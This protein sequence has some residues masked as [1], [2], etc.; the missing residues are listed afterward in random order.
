MHLCECPACAK[1]VADDMSAHRA[2]AAV[3]SRIAYCLLIHKSPEQVNDFIRQLLSD[4]SADVYVHI[5]AKA[6]DALHGQI[7]TSPRVRILDTSMAC[8]WGDISLVDATLLLIRAV[9]Q[10]GK[11]YD[12]VCLRSGQDLVVRNGY[13]EYLKAAKTRNFI[14]I[15]KL[16][17]TRSE[18]AFF[19][20]R[21]P[22]RTRQLYDG[23]HPYRL[24]RGLLTRLYLLGIN[25][26]PNR[27]S[28]PKRL[29]LYDGSQWFALSA[30]LV[31]CIIA[32]LDN[33]PSYY[34]AFK[35]TLVPDSSFFQTLIMNSAFAPTVV[36]D[37]QV[38]VRWGS[39]LR[40]YNHPMALTSADV[41]SIEASGQFF[42]RK[43]DVNVDSR[44]ITYFVDKVCKTA[45]THV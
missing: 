11:S 8:A 20:V 32:Y 25:I 10:S 40:D 9:I 15:R 17:R 4:E 2:R 45:E 1:D 7:L 30:H 41:P 18:T 37:Y 24:L 29:D 5:D 3:G 36:N 22:R 13:H 33:H 28:L 23:M 21:W 38:Y 31:R 19:D 6:R 14:G 27:H 26:R 12:F 42:A 16:P 35:D 34:E 44:V 39:G 43:F